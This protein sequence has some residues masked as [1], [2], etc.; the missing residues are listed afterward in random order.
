MQAIVE[1]CASG[2]IPGVP[3]AVVSNNSSSAALA[4]ARDRQVPAFHISTKDLGTDEAVDEKITQTLLAQSAELVILSGYMRMVGPML[5]EAFP[6]RILNVHP[7]LLPAFGGKGMY[8]IR[9]HEAVLR[10]GVKE[11][12]VT[13]HLVDGEYD[14]GPVLSQRTAPVL[15]GD[16]PETLQA[17][18][19]PLEISLYVEVVRDLCR[20]SLSSK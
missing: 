13:I 9:V 4:F 6:K 8:G 1:S 12:G 7:S 15:P 10:S 20:K 16:T 3:V 11:T 5:Q 14:T 18:L 19:R 2:E 17:R